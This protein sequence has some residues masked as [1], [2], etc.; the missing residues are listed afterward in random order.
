MTF[1]LPGDGPAGA[2]KGRG[3]VRA[4]LLSG[5]T[6]LGKTVLLITAITFIVWAIIT[7]LAY[8]PLNC[9]SGNLS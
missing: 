1:T 9:S 7:A 4:M 6:T 8:T 5:L 2:A 3:S